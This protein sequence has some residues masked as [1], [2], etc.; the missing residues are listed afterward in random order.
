MAERKLGGM[1]LC[2]EFSLEVIDA[3]WMGNRLWDDSVNW[4]LSS[5]SVSLH[6]LIVLSASLTCLARSTSTRCFQSLQ[7]RRQFAAPYL[8]TAPSKMMSRRCG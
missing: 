1:S 8:F 6:E 2:M 4:Q 3:Y 5:S 7:A